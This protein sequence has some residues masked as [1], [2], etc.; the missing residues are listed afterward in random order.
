VLDYSFPFYLMVKKSLNGQHLQQYQ[1]IE[2]TKS[3]TY[4]P[5]NPAS[6]L[7]V[8]IIPVNRANAETMESQNV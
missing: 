8:A 1:T 5:G 4:C 3:M 7:S 2:H 6:S